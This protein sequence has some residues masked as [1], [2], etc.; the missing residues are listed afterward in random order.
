MIARGNGEAATAARR[1]AGRDAGRDAERDAGRDADIR[2]PTADNPPTTDNR[3]SN[4][5]SRF[6]A[7]GRRPSNVGPFPIPAVG[8]RPSNVAAVTQLFAL[9]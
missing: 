6:P 2:H 7:V 3:Q 9:P 4:V 5:A 8:C 1:D